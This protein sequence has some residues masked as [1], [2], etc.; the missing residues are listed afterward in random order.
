MSAVSL[1]SSRFRLVLWKGS[2]RTCRSLRRT[3]RKEAR[4][5]LK[6]ALAETHRFLFQ[7]ESPFLSFALLDAPLRESANLLPFYYCLQLRLARAGAVRL[8]RS[9]RLLVIL[10]ISCAQPIRCT[11]PHH[12]DSGPQT[13]EKLVR[14]SSR[15]KF[16]GAERMIGQACRLEQLLLLSR[17]E[18]GA[19]EKGVLENFLCQDCVSLG[20]QSSPC[21]ACI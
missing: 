16:R 2:N 17:V 6:C 5:C 1:S 21:L 18:T 13:C 14:S 10:R 8:L 11:A 19:W 15:T 4:R 3:G 7:Q 20:G 12:R 9:C